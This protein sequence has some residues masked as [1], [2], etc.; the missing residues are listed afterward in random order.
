MTTISNTGVQ[1][2]IQGV[3][4]DPAGY[5]YIAGT[6]SAGNCLGVKYGPTCYTAFVAKFDPAGTTLIYSRYLAGPPVDPWA[7]VAADSA[8]NAYVAFTERWPS[9]GEPPQPG[10]ATVEKLS[11]DGST[12]VYS[13]SLG[14]NTAAKAIAVD[15][16][17]NVIIAGNSTGTSFPSLHP[18][19][20]Q[21]SVKSLYVTNDGGA[22]WRALNNGLIATNINS[23]A[24]DPK[25]PSTLFAAT[26]NGLYKS[27]DSG[28]HWSQLLPDAAVASSVVIDPRN[29]SNVN[30]TYTNASGTFLARSADSGQTWA[31][32]SD[33]FP[34]QL[35]AIDAV[36]IDPSDSSKLWAIIITPNRSSTVIQSVDS[37]D[38]WQVVYA[39]PPDDRLTLTLVG[40]KLL[41]DPKNS[42]RLYACCIYTPYAVGTGGVYRSDDGG[43]TW[44]QGQIGPLGG[45]LGILS[46]WLDPQSSSVLYGDWYYGLQRSIDAGMTW[47]YVSL[48]SG[49]ADHG[50]EPGSFA[51]DA[52]GTL[53]L[54]NDFGFM[55][56]SAD[57]GESWTT[58]KGPWAP[59][60]SIVAIDPINSSTIY[61]ASGASSQ[62]GGTPPQHAFAAKLD[63]SGA[64]RWATLVG[65]SGQD[66][67]N[68][69]AVDVAGNAYLTGQTNSDDFPAVNAFQ[70]VRGKNT[71][72][73]A[74]AFV[75]K[76]SA[77][78]SKLLY[79]SFLGGNGID[80]GNGI[81]VDAMG[82][83]YIAGGTSFGVFSVVAP[84]TPQ[85]VNP[86]AASFLAKVNPTGDK[87]LYST[88][89]SGTTSPTSDEA[90]AVAVDP[91][92]RAIVVGAT[93]D[94]TIPLVNP[95]QPTIDGQSNFVTTLSASGNAIDFS[96]YLGNEQFGRITDLASAP[97]GSLWIAGANGLAR[98][99]F[100]PPVAQPGIPQVFAVQNAASYIPSSTIAPGEIVTLAGQELAASSQ[101]AS[102]GS[103]PRAMQGASVLI[104]GLAAPLFYVSP[105]QINF[106][107]P[108]EL[109]LGPAA[110]VVQRGDQQSAVQNLNIVAAQPGLFPATND[111]RGTPLVVHAADFSLV[112]E[113]NPAHPGEY[114][115]A[116]FTGLGATIPAAISGEPATGP[117]SLAGGIIAFLGGVGQTVSY[118]GLAPGWVGLYQVN[119]VLRADVSPGQN[120][121]FLYVGQYD[122][123][124]AQIWVR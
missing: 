99:D 103:L 20:I 32:I 118:A 28:A 37:G 14:G 98:I 58:T 85:P 60:A 70:T 96:T 42:S 6:A 53:Y 24:V 81:A 109:P 33:N 104:G 47:N 114:L 13:R 106:E 91:R 88:L 74:S 64:I 29:S 94:P 87:L 82:N 3:A 79:S 84:L 111:V 93:A 19:P 54:L 124:Q 57:A 34:P 68:S 23:L 86:K 51:L 2:N 72:A 102:S 76:I 55:L 40:M 105:T 22:T 4:V 69:V 46:P 119:F 95:I 66:S 77:D 75:T 108:V 1:G 61:V 115:A 120:Q 83:A 90:V 45:P 63:A 71:F 113:Q 18:L 21:P 89:L 62:L 67:A 7:S 56:K 41:I 39:F 121:L 97:N 8:G 59:L 30:V 38:H 107:V 35:G 49:I 73:T 50:Y 116:F 36:A 9:F 44:V 15:V 112:T 27:T 16:N 100:Q 26:S 10:N 31:K 17:E 110:L 12:V 78:G 117:A 65:G 101:T 123:N 122:S 43:N 25:N 92:G 48:P 11:P 80:S 5:I 52:T